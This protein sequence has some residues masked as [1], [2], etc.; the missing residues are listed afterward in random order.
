MTKLTYV[1]IF[2]MASGSAWAQINEIMDAAGDG[3]G[4]ALEFPRAVVVDSQG[5]V[6]VAGM[7]SNNVFRLD[8][9]SPCN[10]SSQPCQWT[11]IMDSSAAGVPGQ[12]LLAPHALAVDDLDNLYVAGRFSDN[13]WRINNPQNCST[14]STP[15]DIHE[16][17]NIDGDGTHEMDGPFDVVV[18]PM[19][20][21]YVAGT[22]SN[23]VFRLAASDSCSTGGTPCDITEIVD[24]TGDGSNNF[25]QPGALA[26]DP[27]GHVYSSN[28]GD[29]VFKIELPGDCNTTAG[30][31]VVTEIM[32]EDDF[33]TLDLG[34]GLVADSLGHVY[35]SSLG[36]GVGP[37]VY[38]IDV[39]QSCGTSGAG[40]AITE[41][42]SS[43][44][45]QQVF[46]LAIDA[47]DNVYLAGGNGDNAFRIDRP[48]D[49][50]AL[51]DPC[52]ITS[53]IDATGDGSAMLSGARELAVGGRD[54]YVLGADSDNAFRL[55]GV[56]DLSDLIFEDDFE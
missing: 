33:G 38:Q 50:N 28:F 54:V 13:V 7:D 14:S 49:C 46:A 20:H 25:F 27:M 52:Q 41:I 44:S 2:A 43:T 32:N 37:K 34:N 4:Q 31:C 35:V 45:P 47:A 42:F 30:D 23:N 40:C 10:T 17:I 26:I 24:G 55:H 39:S 18:D 5:R 6:Y 36:S 1:M 21:V 56:A 3:M 48:E 51:T 19:N 8:T 53:L 29:N 16:I 15:C 9:A 12:S 22:S 11:E